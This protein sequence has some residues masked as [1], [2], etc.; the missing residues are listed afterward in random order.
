MQEIMSMLKSILKIILGLLIGVV[1]GLL[2]AA[3][4]LICFTDT[5]LPGFL[6]KLASTSFLVAMGAAGFGILIFALSIAI[7]IPLHEAGH[8]VC[9]LMSGYKFVS[10]RIFNL[11]F[12]K[13]D[14]KLKIK[15]YSIAGTGGQCLLTPPDLPIEK[16]PTGWYNSGGVLFNI[17]AVLA[18]APLLLINNPFAKEAAVIFTL[19]GAFLILMNGIPMKIS[20]AGN[21]AYNML[22]LKKNLLAKRGLVEALRANAM[23]QNG[24]RPKDMPD[25]W[26]V[27]PDDI[28][29]SDQLETSIPMMAASRF[30]DEM[31]FQEALRSF[32][33]LY[34][35]KNE[36]IGLYVKEIECELVFLYI[37][38]GDMGKA[39][40]LLT[41]KLRKYIETYRQVMS[42]KQRILCTM[43]L[44]I[45]NER[46]KAIGIYEDLLAKE[47]NYLLQGEVKSDLAIMKSL[48][49]I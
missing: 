43:A 19:T 5:T 26:F 3:I 49:E 2:I 30:I 36:I 10:F 23:I 6:S 16:I 12:I 32:E 15:R 9:G 44:F 39:T 35:H 45:D 14:G 25:D 21:D 8:L 22:A 46:D 17:I 40:E 20:R 11:T 4:G 38:N 47:N 7:L 48:L 31:N 29:Y 28:D 41:P 1:A 24:V 33:E 42:C 34:S 27:I 37:V 18:V 13:S